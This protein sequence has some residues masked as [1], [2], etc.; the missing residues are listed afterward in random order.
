MLLVLLYLLIQ[1]IFSTRF[2]PL[3]HNLCHP[4][5]VFERSWGLEFFFLGVEVVPIQTGIL[6]SRLQYILDLMKPACIEL[7]RSP[8]LNFSLILYRL[9]ALPY[10]MSQN[11][12]HFLDVF[13]I[14]HTLGTRTSLLMFIGL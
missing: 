5:F 7:K 14:C 12:A 6:V 13:S 8:H 10:P 3:P 1:L 2:H 9:L 4:Q 11:I